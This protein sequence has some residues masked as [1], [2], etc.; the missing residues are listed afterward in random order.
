ML[1]EKCI[2]VMFGA[3]FKNFDITDKSFIDFIIKQVPIDFTNGD[4][5]EF[6]FM[7]V[8]GQHEYEYLLEL[9]YRYHGYHASRADYSTS[10]RDPFSVLLRTLINLMGTE[11]L[12]G[13]RD[14]Y[15]DAGILK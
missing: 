7:P 12:I 13:L 6:M 8:D 4:M 11:Y 3:V 14:L 1:L 2:D 15:S 5:A 9:Y 10:L